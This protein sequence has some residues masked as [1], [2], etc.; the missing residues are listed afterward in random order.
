[1][2]RRYCKCGRKIVVFRSKGRKGVKQG[3]EDHDLCQRCWE[4]FQN[5][6]RWI[7]PKADKEPDLC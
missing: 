7:R 2:A 6:S 1:M 5:S 3:K 4:S